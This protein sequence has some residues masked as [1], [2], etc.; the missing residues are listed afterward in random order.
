MP[1]MNG[2][3]ITPPSHVGEAG[4]NGSHNAMLAI[5]P[6]TIAVRLTTDLGSD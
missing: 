5:V 6:S 2:M 1:K 3:K 4:T